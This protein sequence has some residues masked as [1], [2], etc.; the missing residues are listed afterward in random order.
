MKTKSGINPLSITKYWKDLKPPDIQYLRATKNKFYDNTFPPTLNTLYSK[1]SKGEFMDKVR[2]PKKLKD[3]QEDVSYIQSIVWKRVTEVSP[4]WELFE[5]KIEIN[6]VEQGSLGDCYFLSSIAALAGYPYLIKEKFRTKGF[7]QEGYY[8]MIFFIDG[9]WQIVFIDDYLPYDTSINNFAFAKPNNNE[10]WVMF[11]EKAWAKLNG[12]YS[13]IIGGN[14]NEPICS[15]TGFPTECLSHKNIDEMEIYY[16]I[17]EGDKEGT[18]MSSASKKNNEVEKRGLIASHA[19][20]LMTAK[21]WKDRNIFLIKL[22][23]PG[24]AGEWNGKWGDNSSCWTEE[25]KRYFNFKKCN[26]GIFW[27]NIDDYV[28]NFDCTYICYILYGAIVKNFYFEYQTYF[29]KPVVFNMRVKEKGKMSIG[30]LFKNWRFNRDIHDFSHPFS[31]VVCKYDKNRRIEKLWNN[32]S[33]KDD[34]N[35]VEFFEPGFMLYG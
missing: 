15:L 19:Y 14:I 27:I 2:G 11:L 16:K 18:I 8:E 32:W 23:N 13:N 6:D 26:D 31:M 25:Y 29:K 33:C 9:E 17:E 24:V 28:Q 1:N 12:G 34:M 3:F 30:V 7:N 10:L 35:I 20:T 5:G 4:K 22:R 21:K